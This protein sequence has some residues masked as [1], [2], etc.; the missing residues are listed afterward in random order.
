MSLS[1]KNALHTPATLLTEQDLYLYNEGTHSR[2]Y[3]K[4]GA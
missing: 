3:D 2:V 1:E 4:L